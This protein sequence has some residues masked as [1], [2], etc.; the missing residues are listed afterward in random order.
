M[1]V[2]QFSGTDD[3]YGFIDLLVKRLSTEGLADH[4]A[5]LH[6]LIHDVA[7]TSGSELLGE[8]GLELKR[9]QE[10]HEPHLP[11]DLVEAISRSRAFVREY[12]PDL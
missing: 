12:W 6:T 1:A 5:K 2:E 9:I 11:S 4:A 7:W 3:F 10:L 8:L